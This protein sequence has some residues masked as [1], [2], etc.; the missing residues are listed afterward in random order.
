MNAIGWWNSRR[1]RVIY[2]EREL[3]S[4]RAELVLADAEVER[5]K[6]LLPVMKE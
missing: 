4:A 1:S 2:L 3:E 5:L 6:A